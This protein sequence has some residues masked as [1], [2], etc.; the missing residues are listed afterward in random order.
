MDEAHFQRVVDF[1]RYGRRISQIAHSSFVSFVFISSL[2]NL[3]RNTAPL[4]NGG[5]FCRVLGHCQAEQ[6]QRG[7]SVALC[8]CKVS[9]KSFSKR[10]CLKK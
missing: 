8:A 3:N 9:A 10:D 2:L 7:L 4:L 5:F 1:S 6:E